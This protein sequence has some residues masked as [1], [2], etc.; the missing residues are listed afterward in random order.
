MSSAGACQSFELPASLGALTGVQTL[1]LGGCEGLRDTR[2][3]S[4][5]GKMSMQ[6]AHSLPC[7]NGEA[8][9]APNS[10]HQRPDD[11]LRD[12]Y[13]SARPS[14]SSHV[15]ASAAQVVHGL[16]GASDIAG[17][18]RQVQIFGR[19][20][21]MNLMVEVM[22]EDSIYLDQCARE[23]RDVDGTWKSNGVQTGAQIEEVTDGEEGGCVGG[24]S[25]RMEFEDGTQVGTNMNPFEQQFSLNLPPREDVLFDEFVGESG[26]GT[27]TSS[28]FSLIFRS[29]E[30]T[31]RQTKSTE[32]ER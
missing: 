9:G 30:V 32:G 5:S 28:T 11:V 4:R 1:Y 2:L 19:L 27:A 8:A 23:A 6:R 31:V 16:G 17:G 22:L 10:P 18:Q 25:N 13:L 24:A 14:I 26:E 21:A 3:S 20:A 15:Q 12:V 29:R 7:M